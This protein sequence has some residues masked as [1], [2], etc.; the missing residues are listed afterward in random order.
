MLTSTLAILC[1]ALMVLSMVLHLFGL[2]AN[3]LILLLA[4]AWFS[5]APP[6]SLTMQ[7]LIFMGVLALMGEIL[8]TL[9]LHIWGKK[10]GG[11][12]K[13]TIGGMVGA[14][15]GAILTAP[16]FF[17]LGA[18]FGALAG[19]FTGSLIV[20]L[21]RGM[22]LRKAALAA[23]GSMVGRFGGTVLKASIG[24]VLILLAAPRIWAY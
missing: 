3:W 18:L 1:I 22:E 13:G 24:F 14:I 9:L 16:F 7:T 21:L 6:G 23:Y 2:P 19:A 17:G 8:E 10:Y 12:G 20:E 4:A 15:L 11:S 5:F